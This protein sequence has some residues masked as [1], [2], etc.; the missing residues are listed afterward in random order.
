MTGLNGTGSRMGS[1]HDGWAWFHRNSRLYH[2]L[3]QKVTQEPNL[4]A[5]TFSK[6][7]LCASAIYV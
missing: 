1:G 4:A 3:N 2:L 7:L 6:P 5:D